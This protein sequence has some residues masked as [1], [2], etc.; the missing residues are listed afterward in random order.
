MPSHI[1]HPLATFLVT[2]GALLAFAS[3]AS[4]GVLSFSGAERPL[5]QDWANY[6][7]QSASRVQQVDSPV[8]QGRR[9]YQ[10]EVK[11]GDNSWGERCEIGMGNPSRSGFPLFH[12]GDERWI[13]FQVYLPDD[14]PIDTNMWNVFFQIHQEG[15]GGCPPLALHVENGQWE[16]F[17]SARNTYVLDTRR[18]WSA[19]AHR[20][21]WTK[22]TLH[23]NNS[24]DPKAGFVELFG[25]LD[26][27]GV[28]QLLERTYTH[29]MTKNSGGA[30]T[31][32]A[33]VG[34][35]RNP[36]IR[37][38][39]HILFDGF[40]IA[41]NRASAEASAFGDGPGTTAPVSPSRSSHL[42]WLRAGARQAGVVP[43]RGGARPVRTAAGRK[44]KIQVRRGGRWHWFARGWV[45]GDG[46]FTL[47]ARVG[48]A[49]PRLMLR[50]VIAGVGHSRAVAA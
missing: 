8:A 10:L 20:N 2:L 24:P 25:D 50:A 31:N 19:P 30:M 37:G 44:V 17:N 35:Y 38:T 47:A 5:A 15:D 42:V 49:R 1:R 36:G 12:T 14:Y 39:T 21:R 41:T 34:I 13:S 9:S 18:L 28:K 23:L 33:R 22:F 6:S 45:Q 16:M 32:H 27:Q 4:A 43:L 11:D 48:G 7:C 3:S 46:R 26:G 40:T 29:T